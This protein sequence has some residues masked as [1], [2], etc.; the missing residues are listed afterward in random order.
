MS[1]TPQQ[2]TTVT[3]LLAALAAQLESDDEARAVLEASA[4]SRRVDVTLYIDHGRVGVKPVGVR[5]S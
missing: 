1:T 5:I 4:F 2:T 3:E